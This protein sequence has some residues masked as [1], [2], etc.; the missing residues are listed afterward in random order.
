MELEII[1][2]TEFVTHDSLRRA[3]DKLGKLLQ[4]TS[5]SAYLT[6]FRNTLLA[7]PVITEDEKLDD[8]CSGVKPQ[9]KLKVLKSDPTT[10]EQAT[11]IALNVDSALFGAGMFNH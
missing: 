7:M 3:G 1:L 10:F 9:V 4:I 5:V 2:R 6:E 11:Q 8:F